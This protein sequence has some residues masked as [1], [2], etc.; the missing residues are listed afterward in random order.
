MFE[1]LTVRRHPN[2]TY[3]PIFDPMYNCHG[4]T[5]ASRRTQISHTADVIHVLRE[6]GYRLIKATDVLPGD[7]IV[8][9]EDD[10]EISH[11]GIVVEVRDGMTRSFRIW[12]KWSAFGK[13]VVHWAD[14]CPYAGCHRMG[15]YRLS[16]I[17]G[18]QEWSKAIL[19]QS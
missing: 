19:I 8:Y 3:R 18:G 14:Q 12:S 6:D 11:T 1:G 2:E 10:G 7:V 16:P 4:L 17:E 5:F 9:W 13:E 15:F